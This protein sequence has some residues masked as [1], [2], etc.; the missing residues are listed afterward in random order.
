MASVEGTRRRL[1]HALCLGVLALALS[2]TAGALNSPR[3]ALAA[4]DSTSRVVDAFG[5][6]MDRYWSWDARQFYWRSDHKAHDGNRFAPMWWSA[7]LWE[8]LM[9]NYER[10]GSS[11]DRQLIDV[12]YEGWVQHHNGIHSEYNDDVGWWAL[13]ATRAY[14][15][16]HEP[17]YL[18][19]A[20]KIADRQWND[21]DG[22][23]GGGIW[24][25]RTARDQK[26]VATNGTA[27]IVNATLY[28]YTGS[29]R[30]KKH[31][32]ALF[33]WVDSKLRSGGRL[34]DRI[35]RYNRIQVDYS[36]NYGSYIGAA[37]ALYRIT[38]SGSYVERATSLADSAL[39]R[40]VNSSGVLR[41][42]GTGDGGGFKGIFMRNL[43]WLANARAVSSARRSNYANFIEHNAAVAWSHRISSRLWGASWTRT[44]SPPVEAL[45]DASAVSLFQ[46]DAMTP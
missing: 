17:R 39:G 40:L 2:V 6:F 19:V 16:T 1:Q 42:E 13:A 12:I 8:T 27:A 34:D 35:E 3:P 18:N 43:R 25:R 10:T 7:Q 38:G 22:T 31:A 33:A 4:T 46:G 28:R 21:W 45:T 23:Y 32:V 30:F 14:N 20:I 11:V 26:N 44:A 24:W 15:I 37:L 36:Y 41:S 9:D 29:A 5:K